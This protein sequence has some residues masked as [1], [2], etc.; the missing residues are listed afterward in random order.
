[1][2][3]VFIISFLVLVTSFSLFAQ[4][5]Q[6]EIYNPPIPYV[7]NNTDWGADLLVSST[8]PFGRPS[9]VYQLSNTTLYIAIPDT[10]IVSNRC[11][12]V[13]KSSNNGENWSVHSSVQPATMIPKLKMVQSADSIY[14]FFLYGTT[15]YCWNI[16]SNSLNQFTTYTDIRD[17]DVTISST[18]SLYLIIDLHTSNQ[19]RFFG[20]TTGGATW[21][22]SVYLSSAAAHPTISMSG[23][24]DTALINYY[25]P[26]LADTLTSAIRNV[27][28]R[29]SAP[30]T[31]TIVGSFTTPIA[32]GTTKDQFIGVINSGNAWI[33]YTLGTTG[34]IDLNCI[35]SIDNGTTYGSPVTIHALPSRDEYW[36]DAKYF[37]F[38]SDGVDV[39]YY[40]DSLQT[41][42]STNVTDILYYTSAANSTPTTFD[43]PVRV[44]N[45]PPEWSP[46]M[47]IPSLIEY[48]DVTGDV[49]ALWVGIDASTKKLYF[50]RLGNVTRIKKN[51]V[52]VPGEYT[53]GQNYPNPFNPVTKFDFAITKNSFV[54]IKV[55]DIT[56][57]EMVTIVNKEMTSGSYSVTFDASNITSGVYFYKLTTAEFTDTKRMIVLK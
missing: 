40:S 49:G 57:R 52:F 36:F 3:K 45:H 10:N 24:G 42:G 13:L 51:E 56:G 55:Y 39:I 4:E 25:G 44:S 33:F 12:V 27:R 19:V 7:G 34:S 15:I 21:P 46:L 18:G 6:V 11:I 9:G 28:Y 47:Y 53:L 37:T 14:C 43:T 1:M 50:D 31:L 38:G 54:T 30:G 22:T 20:S 32:A 41:G 35:S 23:S 5:L 2:K 48:Y 16:I 17:F 8:E 26:V 29:E